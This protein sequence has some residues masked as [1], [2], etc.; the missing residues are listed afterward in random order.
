MGEAK[1]LNCRR[2][3]GTHAGRGLSRTKREGRRSGMGR[4][5]PHW[6]F[7]QRRLQP[8]TGVLAHGL[9]ISTY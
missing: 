2:I 4:G 8:M 1:R 6:F 5:E 9:G 3:S 7:E